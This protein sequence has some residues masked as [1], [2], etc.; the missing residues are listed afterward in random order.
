[1]VPHGVRSPWLI[2]IFVQIQVCRESL[3]LEGIDRKYRSIWSESSKSRTINV[4][5]LAEWGTNS[6]VA[7]LEK[8][9]CSHIL[10]GRHFVIASKFDYNHAYNLYESIQISAMQL[11][12]A[13]SPYKVDVLS[14]QNWISSYK[15]H[16]LPA[17]VYLYTQRL[18]QFSCWISND[19]QTLIWRFQAD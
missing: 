7:Q 8:R 15:L 11:E 1:M 5:S 18:L 10:P 3:W 17:T 12:S 2:N 19:I 14:R 13:S 4:L 6:G 9:S 16:T